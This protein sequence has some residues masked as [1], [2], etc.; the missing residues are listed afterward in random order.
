MAEEAAEHP[1]ARFGAA[2]ACRAARMSC[3]PSGSV[4]FRYR[5]T[6]SS[7]YW[8]TAASIKAPMWLHGCVPPSPP[9]GRLLLV[10]Q[11]KPWSAALI[12]DT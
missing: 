9:H 6:R 5:V 4:T 7:P 2:F 12:H 11:L 3:P 10:L 8:A 1:G